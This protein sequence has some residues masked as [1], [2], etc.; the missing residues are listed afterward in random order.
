MLLIDVLLLMMVKRDTYRHGYCDFLYGV[1]TAAAAVFILLLFL[2]TL[3]V[4]KRNHVRGHTVVSIIHLLDN[5]KMHSRFSEL[6][7]LHVQF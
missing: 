3:K 7:F 6:D 5:L 4:V 2:A 1:V